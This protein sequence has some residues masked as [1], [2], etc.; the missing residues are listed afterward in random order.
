MLDFLRGRASERK[1]RLFA[2]AWCRRLWHNLEP[3]RNR[4]AVDVG[5]RYADGAATAEELAAARR[6]A[7]HRVRTA[8]ARHEPTP[9][10]LADHA[11]VYRGTPRDSLVAVLR[12]IFQ[13]F[14]TAPALDPAWL[15]WHDGAVTRLARAAYED[16][17]L[18]EGTLD[19]ARL[20]VL[21]DALEDAGC[22]DTA[23]LGHLRG[24]GPHVRGCWAVDLLLGKS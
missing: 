18:P 24:Q 7:D 9:G 14:G 1:L 13:P 5:E 2:C 11:A 20:A 8:L 23:L 17:R 6:R 4:A 16:R 21:A 22:T 12:D 15:A 3:E 19:P 10:A